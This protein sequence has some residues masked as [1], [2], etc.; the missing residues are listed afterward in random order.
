MTFW[1]IA[2]AMIVLALLFVVPPLMRKALPAAIDDRRE[3]NIVIAREKLTELE[4]DFKAGNIDEAD[5]QQSRQEL[6]V[7]LR[8]DLEA[9]SETAVDV[10]PKRAVGGMLLAGIFVPVCSIGMYLFLGSPELTDST[11]LKAQAAA[12][13]AQEGKATQTDVDEMVTTLREKLEAQPENLTGWLMLGR[14]YMVMQRYEDAA[15]AY[16]KANAVEA[17]NPEILLPLADALA[18]SKQGR[19]EG[20][21]LALINQVLEVAPENPMALWLA[22]MGASQAGDQQTTITY[23]TKLEKLLPEGSEDRLEVRRMLR[24]MGVEIAG[25]V[26][27]TAPAVVNEARSIA[28]T[29][30]LAD[31]LKEKA[32]PEDYVF[33]Y[34]KATA[35]PPMPLAAVRHQVKEFPLSV[36]LN[37]SQA[38]MP[39]MKLSGY[40]EVTVGARISK[41]GKPVASPGDLYGEKTPVKVGGEVQLEIDTVS[42]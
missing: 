32:S 12:A 16:D 20:R 24:E 39:D 36:V 31:A 26:E 10:Q 18:M 21:P 5:Y 4:S 1:L 40:S 38:M 37:D 6:E 34:A 42:Q 14:S 30:D 17:N 41:S 29:V 2:A 11:A 35:G 3:Q 15:Y 25:E 8:D 9:A 13:R 33:V 28:V 22:G 19:M 23:W 7:A 27:P